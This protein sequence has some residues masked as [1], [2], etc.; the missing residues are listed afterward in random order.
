M[1][2]ET[3][4]RL[5]LFVLSELGRAVQSMWGVEQ[6]GL[7]AAK[8][9]NGCTHMPVSL[10][11]ADGQPQV[12]VEVE[13]EDLARE[14]AEVLLHALAKAGLELG[15][16]EAGAADRATAEESWA[17]SATTRDVSCFC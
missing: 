5:F 4:V 11:C 12:E 7:R 14:A 8:P 17:T 13:V 3:M 1:L 16:G 10:L 9:W 2:K 6:R 15:K